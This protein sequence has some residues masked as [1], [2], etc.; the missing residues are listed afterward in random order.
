MWFARSPLVLLCLA[1][2]SC[3]GG[4]PATEANLRID[5]RTDLLPGTEFDGVSAFIGFGDGTESISHVVLSRSD[6]VRGVRLGDLDVVRGEVSL[7]VVV[8]ADGEP[9][10]ERPVTVNVQ[11]SSVVTVVITRDCRGVMCPAPA[12]NSLAVACLGGRCEDPRCTP[13]TPEFCLNEGCGSDAECDDGC[14]IGSCVSGACI[15]SPDDASCSAGERC[16]VDLGCRVDDRRDAGMMDGSIDASF[17]AGL[18]AGTDAGLDAGSD[19]GPDAGFDASTDAGGPDGGPDGG[20]LVDAGTDAGGPDAG[21]TDAGPAFDANVM[22]GMLPTPAGPCDPLLQTGCSDSQK[23]QV[24]RTGYESMC[25]RRGTALLN[26]SCATGDCTEGLL[27]L[28]FGSGTGIAHCRA[29]C[30]SDCGC[31]DPMA[32][33][34]ANPDSYGYCV[35]SACDPVT[36][37]GCPMDQYCVISG[38]RTLCADAVGTIGIGEPCPMNGCLP[39]LLCLSVDAAPAACFEACRVAE[40]TCAC[41]SIT[42][43]GVFGYC[44]M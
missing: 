29:L 37:S 39:G 15:V 26:D 33:C 12:G 13:A 7:R 23:C 18:D 19:A 32:Q 9:I 2:V 5:L 40:G 6:Y 38:G 21:P 44:V 25:A 17:D 41:N 8:Y 34:N 43:D 22:C 14:L 16:D 31:A 20:P 42:G 4:S 1:L 3:S 10:I 24:T 30:S 36:N 28:R 11:T 27:C 35:D